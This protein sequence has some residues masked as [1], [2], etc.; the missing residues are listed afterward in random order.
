M[1]YPRFEADGM[2][3]LVEFLKASAGRSRETR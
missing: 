1:A 2:M 3:D